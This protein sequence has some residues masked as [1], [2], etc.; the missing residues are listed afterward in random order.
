MRIFKFGG[1]SVKDADGVKNVA[2]VLRSQGLNNVLVVISAMG[3]MT[4]AFEE[5]I[6]AYFYQQENSEDNLKEAISFVEDFHHE[7]ITDLFEENH[8]IFNKVDFLFAK[9]SGFMIQNNSKN[10]NYVY[11][12]IVGFGELLSTHIVS[13]YLSEIDI[14]N[15]W[16]DVRECI[17][18]DANFRDAKINWELTSQN[19]TQKINKNISEKT[20][21]ITQGFLGSTSLKI[22]SDIVE[23]NQ[24]FTATTTLGR[25][26]S[27]YTAGV[28]AYCLNAQSVTIWKDVA[29][30]LNADP[31]VFSKTTL[32]HEISYTEAIE[33]AF[34]GASVIHP[35]TIQPLEQK[36]IPLFVRSFEDISNKGTCVGKGTKINPEIP[37]FIVK[38]NQILV[39]ISAKDFSFMVESNISHVFEKLDEY[40]L[41]V[42]LIQNS[43]ISFSVCIED[44][45]N[46]F[47]SFYQD[48]K[49]TFIIKV[50]KDVTLYTIRHFD[51]KALQKIREKGTAIIRQ[52]NT[53]TAQLLIQ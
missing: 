42:N 27:D 3:K 49:S 50:Y 1:A 28:F 10:Y 17:K 14:K 4:N 21:Y 38:K 31:R 5:I 29:G 37:C 40:Q 23:G 24:N 51:E 52:I 16:I 34:Y 47:D 45:Y 43:A 53:E 30:V 44:K 9:L 22:A 15:Q 36:N 8:E 33:M 13:A 11:D 20:I 7:I 35:K 46:T 26:G 48:L 41:K 39:S 18:T 25:E 32:L 12:Q 2:R 6:N 19:I